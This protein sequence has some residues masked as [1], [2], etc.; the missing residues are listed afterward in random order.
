MSSGKANWFEDTV[1]FHHLGLIYEIDNRLGGDMDTDVGDVSQQL[2]DKIGVIKE[3]TATRICMVMVWECRPVTDKV[4]T[5]QLKLPAAAGT[6]PEYRSS[7]IGGCNPFLTS[8]VD[9]KEPIEVI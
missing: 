9:C 4:L 2:L 1:T 7:V 6:T 8:S 5:P 3:G